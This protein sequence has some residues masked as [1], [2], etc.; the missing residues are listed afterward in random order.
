MKVKLLA[1]IIQTDTGDVY[2]VALSEDDTKIIHNLI[3]NMHGGSI[4]A[5]PN[6]LNSITLE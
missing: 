3:T 5:L 6:K 2:Q 4:K 1:V